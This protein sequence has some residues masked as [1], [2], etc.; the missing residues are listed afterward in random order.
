MNSKMRRK[1]NSG[2]TAN[3]RPKR[4]PVS[5]SSRNTRV[6]R[7][8]RRVRPG[9]IA[10]DLITK[11]ARRL[12]NAAYRNLRGRGGWRAVA[13]RF[14]LSSK[15]RAR[16]MAKGR[17]PVCDEMRRI[18]WTASPRELRRFVRRVAIPFLVQR[19]ARPDGRYVRARR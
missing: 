17:R 12:L 14:G 5:K 6:T 3:S 2:R 18:A 15:A 8:T 19:L 1:G 4:A 7:P 13:E 10:Q 9:G 11:R 16:L